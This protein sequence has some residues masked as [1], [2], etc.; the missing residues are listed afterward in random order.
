MDHEESRTAVLAA[1]VANIVIAVGKLEA[2]LLTGSGAMLAEAVDSMA[3]SVNQAFLLIGIRLSDTRPDEEHPH[4]YGKEA[5]FWSFVA[6]LFIFVAGATFSYFE[7]IR[8]LVE[9][10][11]HERESIELI[12]AFVVLGLAFLFEG[13]VL[14]IATRTLRRGARARGW[15]FWM[16]VRE[17][18]ELTTKTVFWE[19]SAATLGLVVAALGLGLTELTSSEA[20]DGAASIVIGLILTA[21]ALML[22]LQARSL[23]LGAAAHRDVR[24]ALRSRIL[25]FDEVEVIVRLL[26]MQLGARSILVTAELQ[27]VD[28]L[29]TTAIEDLL[30]RIEDAVREAEP[31]VSDSF[32]ELR[33]HPL[34]TSVGRRVFETPDR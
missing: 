18:P 15:S 32:F 26:T 20:W 33:Q 10:E 14:I 27:I 16:F 24:D 29:T 13:T 5:F 3:D 28:G 1:L 31:D 34:D 9:G 6:A 4:G 23:L 2:G 11:F 8:T 30:Q 12:V 25:S 7:G 22:G 17:S 19:D 21:V